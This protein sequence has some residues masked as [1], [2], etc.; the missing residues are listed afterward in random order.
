MTM[1][2][3]LDQ[4]TPLDQDE[5]CENCGSSDLR[6]AHV[7]SA[8][9]HEDRLVVVE[10][11]PAIVCDSCGEQLYDDDTVIVLD[12]MRGDGFPADRARREV[13]VP[14]FSFRDRKPNGE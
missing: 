6:V 10:D 9:W 4:S 3:P 12:L 7:R 14:V 11:V 5:T 2:A 1:I 13:R 8:F